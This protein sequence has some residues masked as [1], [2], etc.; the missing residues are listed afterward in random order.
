MPPK[1][2]KKIKQAVH[3]TSIYYL[4]RS[5]R[6]HFFA[7]RHRH[8]W[9]KSGRPIPPPDV[10]KQDVVKEYANRY[11]L[12]TLVETGTYL[13]DMVQ[14]MKHQFDQVYTIEL[15]EQLAS[16]AR[17]RFAS[18][19]NVT[20]IEGDSGAILKTLVPALTKP[21]LF[22]LDA[23]YSGGLTARGIINTP[24]LKELSYILTCEAPDH[25][26]LVDDARCFGV[27]EGYPSLELVVRLVAEIAPSYEVSLTHDIIRIVPQTV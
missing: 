13:G 25:V 8:N 20:V 16:Q 12:Q 23:H 21:A 6:S 5:W 9:E 24:I 19:S 1:M 27:E 17:Q 3:G 22:W 14:E 7:N 26:I 2:R 11:G 10:V 15:G 4:F 18:D